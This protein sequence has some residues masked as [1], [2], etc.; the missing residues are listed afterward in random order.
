MPSFSLDDWIAE[1]SL[2]LFSPEQRDPEMQYLALRCPCG[3]DVFR[4]SGWPRLALGTGGYLWQ[5]LLRVW[6]EAREPMN[7]GEPEQSPFLLPVTLECDRCGRTAP[8]FERTGLAS[9]LDRLDRVPPR[10]SYR[11]RVC[12]RGRVALVV[13]LSDPATDPKSARIGESAQWSRQAGRHAVEVV[14]RCHACRRQARIAWADARPSPQERR[15][16]ALYGR[17]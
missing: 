10:E 7:G 12:R 14:A 3:G 11:C 2:H 13:G 16:D 4:L 5:T 15:L 1:E 17:I 8:L 9:E 6:R